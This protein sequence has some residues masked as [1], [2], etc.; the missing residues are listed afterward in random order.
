MEAGL[1]L[2][3]ARLLIALIPLRHWRSTLGEVTPHAE[4]QLPVEP[5]T[6]LQNL[7]RAVHR[8][9][10]L[11]PPQFVCLP[12]AMAVQWMA[13][14]RGYVTELIIG[15]HPASSERAVG[16]HAWVEYG[17]VTLI[18]EDTAQDFR[19]ALRLGGKHTRSDRF[20]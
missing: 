11:L 1:C 14:R 16:L 6:D 18:G 2:L 12:Q 13:R 10:I 4:Q 20:P 3:L 15:V 19:A 5:T 7:I 9:A 8:A 17:P